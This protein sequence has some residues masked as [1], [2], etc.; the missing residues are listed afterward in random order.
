MNQKCWDHLLNHVLI[1]GNQV[2]F[3]NFSPQKVLIQS[4]LSIES[5]QALRGLLVSIAQ[6]PSFLL[7]LLVLVFLPSVDTQLQ[8]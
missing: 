1:L 4:L 5:A 3:V 6:C 8:P 2:I 7:V